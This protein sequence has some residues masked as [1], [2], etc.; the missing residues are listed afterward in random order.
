MGLVGRRRGR[1]GRRRRLLLRSVSYG[2]L[3]FV[4]WAGLGFCLDELFDV[5]V[6]EFELKWLRNLF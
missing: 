3:G 4:R 5:V 1:G 6:I 2:G